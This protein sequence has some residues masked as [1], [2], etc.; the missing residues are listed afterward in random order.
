MSSIRALTSQLTSW[1]IGGSGSLAA[2]RKR[3]AAVL[4]L[5]AAGEAEGVAHPERPAGLELLDD[6]RAAAKERVAL[7][8]LLLPGDRLA[9]QADTARGRRDRCS[10][11]RSGRRARGYA[12]PCRRRYG[13]SS[14]SGYPLTCSSFPRKREPRASGARGPWAPLSRGRRQFSMTALLRPVPRSGCRAAWRRRRPWRNR[15]R[16]S[17]RAARRR[18]GSWRRSRGL[19]LGLVSTRVETS[20]KLEFEMRE[21]GRDADIVGAAQ[22]FDNRADL[23][24]AALDRREA[25]ALPV[26]ERRQS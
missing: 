2:G 14:S 11:R 16:R 25:V 18:R 19:M 10:P 26:F 9:Q 13:R 23:A 20:G 21:V 17:R 24:L 5:G 22:Q 3:D 12:R 1:R 15:P 6:R 8:L 7:A 4:H